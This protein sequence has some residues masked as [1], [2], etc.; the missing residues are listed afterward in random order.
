MRL[1]NYDDMLYP[2]Y[3]HKFAKVLDH[4]MWAYLQKAAAEKLAQHHGAPE[5]QAH[6]QSIVDGVVPFGYRVAE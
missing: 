4:G 5:V 2:Q 6:W 1:V 3:D